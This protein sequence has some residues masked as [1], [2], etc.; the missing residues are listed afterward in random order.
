MRYH[1]LEFL[2]YNRRIQYN[3]LIYILK[4]NI[5]KFERIITPLEN[6]AFIIQ[7]DQITN[8]NSW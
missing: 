4:N 6:T 8:M 7:P 1:N 3:K 5:L 2:T